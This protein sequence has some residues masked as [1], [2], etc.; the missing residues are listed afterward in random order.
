MKYFIIIIFFLFISCN[1][2]QWSDLDQKVF[3]QDCTDAG[4]TLNKCTCLLSCV[5]QDFKSYEHASINF[6]QNQ[7]SEQLSVCTS[8]CN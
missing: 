6:I 4:E 1:N 3:I 5:M 7:S 8:K 2:N